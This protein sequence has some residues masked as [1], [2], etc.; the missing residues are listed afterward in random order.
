M[1]H[2]GAG[3]M[4]EVYRARDTRLDRSVA[5]K[6]LPHDLIADATARRRFEREARAAAAL[7]HPH[8]CTVLDVGRQDA[9]DYLVL[10]FVDGET[11]ASCL[12]RE[13]LPVR[14]TLRIA[15]EMA[16]ALVAA[17]TVGIVH[18]DIKPGNVMLRPD[19]F[20]KVL[21]FGL[22]KLVGPIPT[23]GGETTQALSTHAGLIVGTVAYMS[24]EQARGGDVD[25][26]SDLWSLGCV[27]Y[28][29]AAGRQPFAGTSTTDVIAAVLQSDPVPLSV[30]DP[31]VPAW[32]SS[33][34]SP[35][36]CA[37]IAR[38][39]TRRRRTCSST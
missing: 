27:L 1:G 13:R 15:I 38:S 19:G 16:E 3:G 11:L 18:R 30:I 2:V 32:S 20:V 17:H 8:I 37:R 5:L 35:R 4:G 7:T 26:R 24:P 33:A 10:E 29:M 25:A 22:A 28:E 6:V 23:D 36:R 9:L 31:T 12:A 21:D 34:S 39:A 14:E